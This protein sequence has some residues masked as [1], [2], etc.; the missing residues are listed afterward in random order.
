MCCSACL[1]WIAQRQEKGEGEGGMF[2]SSAPLLPVPTSA[3][4]SPRGAPQAN[5]ISGWIRR[6]HS[7]RAGQGF[8]ANLS[9]FKNFH[10]I[11]WFWNLNDLWAHKALNTKMHEISS[12][13]EFS[14]PRVVTLA[15]STHTAAAPGPRQEPAE[16]K[17]RPGWEPGGICSLP[18]P[19]LSSKGRQG[20][21]KL[22]ACSRHY[23]SF[24]A[25]TLTCAFW[26]GIL[27]L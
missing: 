6:S 18:G 7:G 12:P 4:P 15:G 10:F 21:G 14:G 22:I 20:P 23:L 19:G 27:Y 8:S 26:K 25:Q 9:T 2:P 17:P 5:G 16:P 13:K 24:P 11:A 3:K 1:Q